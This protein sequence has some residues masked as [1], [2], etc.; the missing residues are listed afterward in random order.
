MQIFKNTTTSL[1]LPFFVWPVSAGFPSP[2]EDYLDQPLDLNEY[3]IKNPAATFFVKV[4]G[5]SMIQAGIHNGD[6]LIVDKSLPV[7]DG[8][9]AICFIEGEFTVKRIKKRAGHIYLVPEN[10][11]FKPMKA[12]PGFKVWGV[13]TYVL[14]KP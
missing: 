4:S 2:A 1:P 7:K 14:H 12:K 8:C 6:I 11:K 10:P 13:V 9:V 3:M 5:Q